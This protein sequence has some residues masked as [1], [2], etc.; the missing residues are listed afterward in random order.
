[1]KGD[2]SGL[3]KSLSPCIKESLLKVASHFGA[4]KVEIP[5]LKWSLD[6]SMNSMMTIRFDTIYTRP[7]EGRQVKTSGK[8][9]FKYLT[10]QSKSIMPS[11]I[12]S[13][14]QY[15]SRNIPKSRQRQLEKVR[16]QLKEEF[17]KLLGDNGVLLYP[18][19]PSS[20]NKHFEMFY[21]LV[22]ANY[23]MIFNTLGLPATQVHTGFDKNNLPVGIQIVANAG[24]DH[25]TLA[26][27]REVQK[28]FGGWI[29]PEEVAS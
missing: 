27:A 28:N 10:G 6:I 23:L 17:S 5:L 11:V 3:P 19:F 8:E 15:L 18:T 12:I 14:F 20:A 13:T 24:M 7:E 22:D 1:M 4:K 25:L 2:R 26:V 16:L 21:K 29:P 9:M